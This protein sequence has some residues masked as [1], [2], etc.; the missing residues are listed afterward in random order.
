MLESIPGHDRYLDPP[1]LQECDC[2][3]IRCTEDYCPC[4]CFDCRTRWRRGVE[5]E[6]S[7]LLVDSHE[8]VE[9]PD[10]YKERKELKE[11]DNAD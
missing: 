6:D 10:L 2:A 7:D 4:R 5:F 3:L 1:D 11:I 8:M 9:E